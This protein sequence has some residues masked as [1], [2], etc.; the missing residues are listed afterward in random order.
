MMVYILLVI[1]LCFGVIKNI[2]PKVAGKEF[3]GFSN[4]MVVN[5][6]TAILAMLVFF[7]SGVGFLYMTNAMFIL[8]AAAYGFCTLGS[9]SL[10]MIAVKK[11][12][13]S[14]C[15]LI[16][17]ACFIIPT[18]FT[19]IYS[20]ERF[21]VFRAVGI[22]VMLASVFMVSAKSYTKS[23]NTSKRY[24]IP[25][26]LAMISAGGMGILQRIFVQQYNGEGLNEFLFLSFAFMLVISVV[27]KLLVKDKDDME[28]KYERKFYVLALLMSVCVVA[29]NKLN[30]WLVVELPG[31]LFFPV[32][33]GGTT[34]LS[35]LTSRAMFNE[36]LS[37]LGW[38]GIIIGVGAIVL[39]AM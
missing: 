31:M 6:I 3:S 11:G 1:S 24:L 26:F 17:A 21:S 23:E 12:S 4:L 16:Y 30:L 20:G 39:I 35:T 33:N 28:V 38:A 15:S 7:V 5:I 37:V 13:V 25:A 36:R 9:Q 10:Y 2:V 19:A 34:M 14:I 22:V 32:I 29:A 8:L 18:V 27:L